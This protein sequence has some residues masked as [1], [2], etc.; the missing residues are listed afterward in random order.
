MVVDGGRHDR[1]PGRRARRAARPRVAVRRHR[2]HPPAGARG[3][4]ARVLRLAAHPGRAGEGRG[5]RRAARRR[6]AAHRAG[7]ADHRRWSSRPAG[8]WCSPST[9]GTSSTRSAAATSSARSSATWP[10]SPGR[11]GSTS[12]PAPVARWTSWC[13]RSTRRW[14]VGR[15]ACPTGRLNAVPRGARRRAPA[16]AARRQAAAD[17]VRHPGRRPGRP[18]SCCSR[19]GSSRP[20]TAASSSAGCARSSASSGTPI[21]INLRIREKRGAEVGAREA[22]DAG[23]SRGWAAGRSVAPPF[24]SRT[25]RLG[26]VRCGWPRPGASGQTCFGTC[27]SS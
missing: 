1:R 23:P 20:G 16:P 17:P 13:R 5:G 14:P 9:S 24:G 4:R 21:R 2:R 6:R 7:P 22:R 18:R 10:R 27:R 15:P 11:R 26:G 3:Q 12:R 25:G 8:R 19:P